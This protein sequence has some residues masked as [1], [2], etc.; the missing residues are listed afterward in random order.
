MDNKDKD[1]VVYGEPIVERVKMGRSWVTVSNY[2]PLHDDPAKR[3]AIYQKAF[4]MLARDGA[5]E[6]AAARRAAQKKGAV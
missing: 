1:D 2:Y 6:R 4:T 5:F 3:Q